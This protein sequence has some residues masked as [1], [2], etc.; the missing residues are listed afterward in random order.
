MANK[1]EKYIVLTPKNDN[2]KKKMDYHGDRWLLRDEVDK[3]KFSREPGP[4]YIIMSRDGKKVLHVKK[5]G[6]P[7]FNVRELG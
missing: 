3:L 5:D 7:D 1:K 2:G 4:F 6:D